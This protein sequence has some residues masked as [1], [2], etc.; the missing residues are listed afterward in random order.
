LSPI[1]HLRDLTDARY[2]FSSRAIVTICLPELLLSFYEGKTID[3]FVQRG[4]KTETI[5]GKI[6][7]SGYVPISYY[8]QPNYGYSQPN[9]GQPIIE[10]DGVLRFGLPASPCFRRWAAIRS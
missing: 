10:V 2:K 5:H 9:V 8:Q 3:F 7:R 4:E 1:S 6:I